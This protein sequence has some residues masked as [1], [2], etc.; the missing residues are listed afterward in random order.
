MFD[1]ALHPRPVLRARRAPAFAAKYWA[2]IDASCQ[3]ATA[4]SGGRL[5]FVR[6]A[7]VPRDAQTAPARGCCAGG[8]CC[9]CEGDT[10]EALVLRYRPAL[11]PALAPWLP[12]DEWAAFV[13]ELDA[14]MALRDGCIDRCAAIAVFAVLFYTTIFGIFCYMCAEHACHRAG[15]RKSRAAVAAALARANARWAPRGLR[16]VGRWH[17]DRAEDRDEP[18]DEE[19]R[20]IA[21]FPLLCIVLPAGAAPPP[22]LAPPVPF[23]LPVAAPATAPMYRP[24]PHP[25]APPP[26]AVLAAALGR[27]G[28]KADAPPPQWAAASAPPRDAPQKGGGDDEDPY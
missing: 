9:A 25:P 8:G 1:Q 2:G 24:L 27:A 6:Q 23:A 14:A 21:D 18:L 16:V 3:A 28:G 11:P 7:W 20:G 4:A 15:V 10:S 13:E 19:G 5:H 22:A 12:R 26:Q 17:A